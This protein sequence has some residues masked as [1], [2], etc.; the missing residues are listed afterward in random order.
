M[1]FRIYIA[2]LAAHNAGIQKGDWVDL[3]GSEEETEILV[4]LIEKGMLGKDNEYAIHDY[5]GF[6]DL[7][8]SSI[9]GA[10]ALAKA[11]DDLGDDNPRPVYCEWC[12]DNGH[13]PAES[14]DTFEEAFR[15]IYAD[16]GDYARETAI[17]CGDI[18]EGSYLFHYIDWERLGREMEIGGDI[19]TI[20]VD[21]SVYKASTPTQTAGVPRSLSSITTF[22][23]PTVSTITP[24]NIAR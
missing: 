2:D 5:E 21:Y 11:C 19:S 22:N 17:D 7:A 18:S 3:D 4:N 8:P 13:D 6:E 20:E 15:G 23:L 9:S 16:A 10:I 14:V 12:E 24:P 1:S